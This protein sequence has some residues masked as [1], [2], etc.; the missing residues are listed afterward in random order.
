MDFIKEKGMNVIIN[1]LP[2]SPGNPISWRSEKESKHWAVKTLGIERIFKLNESQVRLRNESSGII[3][4]GYKHRD[5]FR[6]RQE[7]LP[8]HTNFYPFLIL[9]ISD[10][11]VEKRRARRIVQLTRICNGEAERNFSTNS[12]MSVE[13]TDPERHCQPRSE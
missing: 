5:H 12:A 10:F 8:F 2:R 1:I 3:Q 4:K 9:K 7:L 13:I 6:L 11:F